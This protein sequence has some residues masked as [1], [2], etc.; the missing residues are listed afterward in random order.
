MNNADTLGFAS[1][2]FCGVLALIVA[3]NARRSLAHWAFVVGMAALAAEDAVA[4]V[5][6]LRAESNAAIAARDA[7]RL[8]PLLADDY[9]TF[10]TLSYSGSSDCQSVG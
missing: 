8:R 7:K 4:I 10:V 2:L 1:A 9:E 5:R 6:S 3:W